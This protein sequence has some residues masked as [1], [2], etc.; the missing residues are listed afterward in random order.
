VTDVY[1]A[2]EE[3][4]AG[5]TGAA[6]AQGII[7]HGHKETHYRASLEDAAHYLAQVVEPGDM[8]VTLGAGNVN[9]V[10]SLLADK[11]RGREV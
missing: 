11:L 1:A 2:G 4:I 9:Q 7:E 10:C 6:L 5:A 3:P 8:V